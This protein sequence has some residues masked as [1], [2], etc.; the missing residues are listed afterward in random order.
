MVKIV[1]FLFSDLANLTWSIILYEE[2]LPQKMFAGMFII[3]G[4]DFRQC[5][6]Y[7]AIY[8]KRKIKGIQVV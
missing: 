5:K 7:W 8:D 4:K 6:D 1:A 3:L 2:E